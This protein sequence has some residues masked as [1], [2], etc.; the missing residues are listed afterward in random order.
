[1]SGKIPEALQLS[2]EDVLVLQTSMLVQRL[3]EGGSAKVDLVRWRNGVA[4][5]KVAK[6]EGDREEFLREADTLRLVSGAGGAPHLLAV[7]ERP[8]A[9]LVSF[10]GYQTFHAFR[11]LR[12][13]PDL[14]YLHV[15]RALAECVAEI[16]ATGI[17]HTDL[18]PDNVMVMPPKR[19][20]GLAR[21]RVVDFGHGSRDGQY[22]VIPEGLCHAQYFWVSPEALDGGRISPASDVYSLGVLMKQVASWMQDSPPAL[23]HLAAKATRPRPGDRCDLR[24]VRRALEVMV[25]ERDPRAQ[26]RLRSRCSLASN[27][28]F[29]QMC[30]YY[31]L[32]LLLFPLALLP[33]YLLLPEPFPLLVLLH[34]PLPLL[35]L[36][37]SNAF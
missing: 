16:H 13:P 22:S 4:C 37:S 10:R 2:P 35:L 36:L 21:V 17:I 28:V 3:G 25:R 32:F 33:L 9:L 8:P 29:A 11:S 14:T 20:R 1:M 7:A 27:S 34:F 31:P 12:S 30:R 15:L 5:L 23:S 6:C 26:T 18:K 19:P 24:E